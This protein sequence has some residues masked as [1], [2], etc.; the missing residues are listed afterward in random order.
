MENHL[1]IFTHAENIYLTATELAEPESQR[2]NI[3]N[4]LLALNVLMNDVGLL[5][6][7]GTEINWGPPGSPASLMH[8]IQVTD[9]KQLSG[10]EAIIF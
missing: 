7:L 6:A 4:Q 8:G 5:K 9:I 2:K 1:R 3:S 10:G